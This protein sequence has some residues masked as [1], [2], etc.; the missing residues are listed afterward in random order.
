M[1]ILW[2]KLRADACVLPIIEFATVFIC[3][4]CHIVTTDYR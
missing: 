3:K 2:H 4:V 1:Q